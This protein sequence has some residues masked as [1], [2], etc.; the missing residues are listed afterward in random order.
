[1]TDVSQLELGWL[2][3]I[4]D[5]EGSISVVKRG[6]YTDYQMSLIGDI[7]KLNGRGREHSEA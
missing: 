1:V 3:G 6:P 2:A 5:G 7:R 4:I